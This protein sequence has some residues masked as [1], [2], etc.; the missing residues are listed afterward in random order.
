MRLLSISMAVGFV[1]T[2][3]VNTPRAAPDMADWQT[4]RNDAGGYAFKYPG[5]LSLSIPSGTVCTNGDCKPVEE[6]MLRRYTPADG[7]IRTLQ[8]II[9]RRINPQH[10]LVQQWYESLAHRPLDPAFE[11]TVTMAG[12]TA[13]AR[14]PLVPGVKGRVEVGKTVSAKEALLED[15]TSYVALNDSDILTIS[16]SSGPAEW[17]ELCRGVVSTLTFKKP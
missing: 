10:L 15:D 4:Y 8:F 13:V 2:L 9:Q 14:G 3:A 5:G 1:A 6:V 11:R 16:I 7:S 12:R 17:K